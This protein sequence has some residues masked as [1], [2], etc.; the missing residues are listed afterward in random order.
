MEEHKHW[1]DLIQYG[2]THPSRLGAKFL[3]A[4]LKAL[5]VN[6]G[7]CQ[8]NQGSSNLLTIVKLMMKF[9]CSLGIYKRPLTSI[10]FVHIKR[11]LLGVDEANRCYSK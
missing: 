2:I 10:R 9:M 11:A 6:C 8:R 7:P 1:D 5:K 4:S 3:P